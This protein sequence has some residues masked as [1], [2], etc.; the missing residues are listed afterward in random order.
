MDYKIK[1]LFIQLEN[2]FAQGYHIIRED[3]KKFPKLHQYNHR[4]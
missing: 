4:L 3:A 2:F 1:Q